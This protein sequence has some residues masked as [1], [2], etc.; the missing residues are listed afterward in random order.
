MSLSMLEQIALRFELYASDNEAMAARGLSKRANL[1]RAAVWHDAAKELRKIGADNR[2]AFAIEICNMLPT[3]VCGDIKAE[4]IVSVFITPPIPAPTPR[5]W[6]RPYQQEAVANA[7]LSGK[8][9][10]YNTMQ[11]ERCNEWHPVGV[12]ENGCCPVCCELRDD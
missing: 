2:R 6:L 7:M 5:D 3:M 10:Q 11:C 8:P 12:L 1:A 4:Q 9:E